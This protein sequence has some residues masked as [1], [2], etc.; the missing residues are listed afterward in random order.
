M[1]STSAGSNSA[2]LMGFTGSYSDPSTGLVYEQARWYDPST[3][4]FI[5]VD[6]MVN[7]TQEPYAYVVDDPINNVDPTGLEGSSPPSVW[8]QLQETWRE[9]LINIGVDESVSRLLCRRVLVRLR[10]WLPSSTIRHSWQQTLKKQLITSV[11][12]GTP[13]EVR[14][15]NAATRKGLPHNGQCLCLERMVGHSGESCRR[16]MRGAKSKAIAFARGM[17][18]R[19]SK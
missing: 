6:P 9:L 10:C 7:V 11:A 8:E 5:S 1:K 16:T 17:S 14:A 4:Q 15:A 2:T 13:A 12:T 18:I 3:G 19:S